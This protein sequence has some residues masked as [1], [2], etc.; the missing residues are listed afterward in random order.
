[1]CTDQG[2]PQR[3]FFIVGA[4]RSGTTLLQRMLDA[5]PQMAVARET[6]FMN[7]IWSRRQVFGDIAS[8]TNWRKLL[9]ACERLPPFVDGGYD[10]PS[11]T[12]KV[13]NGPRRYGPLFRSL[14]VELVGS[15]D[16]ALLGEKTPQH[17]LYVSQIEELLPGARFLHIVRDPR[18][19]TA[20]MQRVP[21]SRGE[22]WLDARD[23]RS[24][25]HSI[26]SLSADL[27]VLVYTIRYEDLVGEPVPTLHAICSF[28]GL[29]FD[30]AMLQYHQTPMTGYNVDIN[31]W[32]RNAQRPLFVEGIDRWKH[33]LKPSDIRD[34]EAQVWREMR[35]FDYKLDTNV[36]LLVYDVFRLAVKYNILRVKVRMRR[37]H[38]IFRGLIL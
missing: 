22:V 34:I 36:S 24:R 19:V 5:H 11:F 2:D 16:Y 18:A 21:F 31:P 15:G 13:E 6:H 17:I 29:E 12:K 33:E 14:L 37:R 4:P 9:A 38:A 28:L 23:W 35:Q 1:M 10:G 7:K 26:R 20:S 32:V 30:G 3:L 8:D 27:S 25:I